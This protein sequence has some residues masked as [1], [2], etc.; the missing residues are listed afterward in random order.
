MYGT[1]TK[2]ESL[3][4]IHDA[5]PTDD[6]RRSHFRHSFIMN[7]NNTNYAAVRFLWLLLAILLSCQLK[8]NSGDAHC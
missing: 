4:R 2:Y 3:I 1:E 7:T 5:R 8:L 6:C